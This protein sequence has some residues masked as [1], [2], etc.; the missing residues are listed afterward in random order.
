MNNDSN[1]IQQEQII[2]QN[3]AEESLREATKHT[4][5]GSLEKGLRSVV[6]ALL[7]VPV[8]PKSTLILLIKNNR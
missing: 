7:E 3:N 5:N 4:R 6:V 8:S 1:E 2:M